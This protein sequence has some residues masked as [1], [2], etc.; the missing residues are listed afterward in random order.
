VRFRTAVDFDQSQ[1]YDVVL[2]MSAL[3]VSV[4]DLDGKPVT[5][6]SVRYDGTSPSTA[7]YDGYTFANSVGVGPDGN[8]AL[9]LISGTK[10]V[11]PSIVLKSG[12]A[13]PLNIPQITADKHLFLI[14][15]RTT[16]SILVDD[17][18]PIVRGKPDR[19]PNA[20]D[21][22]NAPVTITWS[23]V[24][25]APSSGTPTT[26]RPTVV[27][28]EGA[29]QVV[30]SDE[31]CDPA[32]NCATGQLKVSI[33]TTA[34]T[35]EAKIT[36]DAKGKRWHKHDAIVT[37]TCDD[38]LSGVAS[39]PGPTTVDHEGAGQKVTGTA[40]DKAGNRNSV[41]ATVN[42][43]KTAPTIE[44]KV[45]QDPNGNGWNNGDVTVAFT[46]DDALSGVASC[47]DPVTLT[48]E[49]PDQVTTGT[50]TD[51]AGNTTTTT[52]TISIDK[53]KPRIT[54]TRTAANSSG[55]NND[56]VTV[57]FACT[58]AMSD[59]ASC[60][61]AVTLVE[62]GADQSVSGTALDKA[63]NTAS[64]TVSEINV[65]K[66]APGITPEVIGA[67]NDA[68]WYNTPPTI[69]YTCTDAL[70]GVALCPADV[71][72]RNDGVHQT[73]KQTAIDHAG[74]TREAEVTDL[75]VD[76]TP[77]DV[78]LVGVD[79]GDRFSL[80]KPPTVSCAT[81]DATSGVA[82]QAV[83]TTTRDSA[84]VYTATCFGAID[85]AGNTAPPKTITYKVIP[86]IPSLIALTNQYIS[87]SGAPQSNGMIQDLDNKL[88]HGQICKYI[89]TVY[90]QKDV[91]NPSLTE[92]QAAE[93]IYWARI[94][95][96]TC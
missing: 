37:F 69:H 58:D 60:T 14:F 32:G 6:A 95:D 45:S 26:P 81:T 50:A 17:R 5:E 47:S 79:N 63:G 1:T 13:I 62:E 16:G 4:R 15:D 24:D 56:D 11:N 93:L 27:D 86:T 10:P 78:T 65:D 57:T 46:C 59:I 43:D 53:T 8:V 44:A 96:P 7:D 9:N 76:L 82:A 73:I 29:D 25:P 23:S 70:S 36:P 20:A 85:L 71:Q 51:E 12:L 55:W 21:W 34:P 40:V 49:G 61:D 77:P 28:T 22:Y 91:E 3:T 92:E 38:A 42:L 74:N 90:K 80:D 52:V 67:K 19:E 33:D 89:A 18:P 68:G 88:W 64:T 35:I 48:E 41:T 75:K 66:T 31:S 39:C 54:A 94:L 83:L 84:G 87:G 30:T 2:P 72:V